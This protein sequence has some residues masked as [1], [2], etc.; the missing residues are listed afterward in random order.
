[1]SILNQKECYLNSTGEIVNLNPKIDAANVFG[2]VVSGYEYINNFIKKRAE[3][4]GG[5][6]N[7]TEW[8]KATAS[9]DKRRFL[10]FEHII[11]NKKIL[12]FNSTNGG[13]LNKAKKVAKSLATVKYT[14]YL[15]EHFK[16]NEIEIYRSIDSIDEKFDIITLFNVIENVPSAEDILQKLSQKLTKGGL[17]IIETQNEND[18][19]IEYYESK[20][21]KE[22]LQMNCRTQLFN[23]NTLSK[24][25]RKAHLKPLSIRQI[26]KFP[27]SN[28]LYWFLNNRPEGHKKW[29]FI[30]KIFPPYL[31]EV[32]LKKYH[33][34]DT[35]VSI[36]SA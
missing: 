34:C 14:P 3:L 9:N 27:L 17:I 12:D 7:M 31:Y 13:F 4:F 1:M 35:L 32:L 26:Q 20:S 8:L 2:N 22:F 16:N 10:Q 30:D 21:F 18:A 15:D 33:T 11:K 29:G 28:H 36:V 25:I 23:V 24:M 19:L 6:K 5:Y